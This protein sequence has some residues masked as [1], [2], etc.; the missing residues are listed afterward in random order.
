MKKPVTVEEQV[1]TSAKAS[2]VP[3][4]VRDRRTL[5]ELARLLRR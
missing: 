1:R 4:K 2:G 3:V 5:L